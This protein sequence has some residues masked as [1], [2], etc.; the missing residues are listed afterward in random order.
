MAFDMKKHGATMD[1]SWLETFDPAAELAAANTDAEPLPP[2]TYT[3]KVMSA[4]ERTFSNPR[5]SGVRVVVRLQ[6]EGHDRTVWD[7]IV[8]QHTPANGGESRAES[9]GRGRLASLFKACGWSNSF[10]TP[11][12]DEL[13]G[14]RVVVDLKIAEWEGRPKNEPKGGYRAATT[15]V[16][17]RF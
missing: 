4:E 3:V 13:A 8:I 5:G 9:I 12:L 7:S 10:Q 16:D 1:M 17:C 6:V 11:T 2:G 14:H 15:E